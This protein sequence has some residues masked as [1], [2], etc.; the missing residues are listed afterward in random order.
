MEVELLMIGNEILIGKTQDTNSNWMA[1]RVTKFGH[2]LKRITTIG[3][4]IE[5]IANTV[6]E[7]LNR[8]PDLI[9]TSGGIGPTFDDMTLAG[10]AKGLGRELEINDHAY[11]S[12]KKAYE[13]AVEKKILK[14]E[15]MTKEREK[16]AFLPKDAIPLPNT[17]GT[18]PGVKIKEHDTDIFILPG[19]PAEMK[20]MFRNV[21]TPIL[22]EKK[23]K[24][25]EKGFL[26]YGIGESQIAAYTNK[27]EEKYP[28]LW[29]KTHPRIGLSV[30]V[31]VSITAFNLENAEKL[32]DDALNEIR[33]IILN[34]GGKIKERD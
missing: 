30:E 13:N 19:V 28:K 21:I 6:Q 4:N 2:K 34:L 18:A 5:V 15:G 10:I 16:M 24:F 22:K 25:V 11:E 12:I 33:E 31:E 26:I 29:I 17:V 7:I 9:I 8:S 32:I 23:G 3:D 20:A 27:L 1:K 14:L